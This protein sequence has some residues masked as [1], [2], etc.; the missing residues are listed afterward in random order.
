MKMVSDLEKLVAECKEKLDLELKKYEENE[1][2]SPAEFNAV[3]F[4]INRAYDELEK[5]LKGEF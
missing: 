5:G 3:F 4:A 2:Y 1:D